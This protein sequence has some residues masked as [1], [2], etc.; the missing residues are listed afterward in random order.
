M[1]RLLRILVL[2]FLL[3]AGLCLHAW[4]VW[5]PKAPT[6]AV[7]AERRTAPL[8][9]RFRSA[10]EHDRVRAA[11]PE[12][13]VLEL[14]HGDGALLYY[15]A[16]HD[17][18][19]DNPQLADIRARWGAFRPTVALCEGRQR[20]YLLGPLFPR[21]VGMPESGLVHELAREHGVPLWSLEPDYAQEVALLAAR[22][23]PEEVALYF[24]LRVYWSEAGG[25]VDEGLAEH[26]RA[27]R[28]DVDGLRGSLPDLA[29]M[30]ATWR[31]LVPAGDWRTWT[32]DMPG[33]LS[34]ID[35]ASR[36][37]RGEHMARI[38]LELVTRG[39]RVLA[40]VGSG[41]VIR[42]EWALRSALGA[43]PAPDQP[44]D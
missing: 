9:V 24:T 31:A 40:V 4:A 11:H 6:Y 16:H 41:H 44:V 28:T 34:E 10:E 8:P 13:Y 32:D 17:T 38:L 7:A 19:L 29:A 22:F 15:G 23:A 26:L 12:A 27:K 1:K 30:D 20:G 42:Q 5:S 3:L 39:E 37:V 21:F 35:H 36:A 43:P 25:Q 33:R 14:A 2:P 18:A